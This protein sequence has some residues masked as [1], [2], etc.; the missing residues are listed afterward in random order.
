MKCAAA[1]LHVDRT[2]RVS[3]D[4]DVVLTDCFSHHNT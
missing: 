1:G 2:V 3:S 4:H